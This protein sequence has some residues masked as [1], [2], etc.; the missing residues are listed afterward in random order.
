MLII[1]G[2]HMHRRTG[3][4]AAAVVA[5][6]A[7]VFA[8]TANAAPA[9]R[10]AGQNCKST[11]KIAFV[12][13]LTGGAAFLGQEQLSW[14]RYAVKTLAPKLGLKIQLLTGDTPVE[15]GPAPAQSLAQKFVADKKVVAIIGPSTSGA[16]AASSQTY[17]DAKLAHISP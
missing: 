3:L 10:A 8:A 13:P 6:L 17:F 5:L 9:Q 14:A 15:Q 4:L 2:G 16:V 11:L 1:Q 12:T 7:S